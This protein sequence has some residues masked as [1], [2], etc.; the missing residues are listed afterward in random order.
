MLAQFLLLTSLYVSAVPC[1][2][3]TQQGIITA[4]YVKA[5]DG[6]VWF[7]LTG[8]PTDKPSCA[9]FKYWMIQDE[10][11]AAA[12]Q[13]IAQLLTAYALGKPIIVYGANTCTRWGDGEDV[14][15]IAIQ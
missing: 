5:S 14:E 11:S 6:L 1:F 2:A 10:T 12:K 7:Y 8:T 9:K 15:T 4:L 3:G 13:Q